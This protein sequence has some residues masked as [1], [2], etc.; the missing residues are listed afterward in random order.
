MERIVEV[1][2]IKKLVSKIFQS[3][4]TVF[5]TKLRSCLKEN[6]TIIQKLLQEAETRETNFVELRQKLERDIICS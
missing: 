2:P 6:D 4:F 1:T 3:D 5:E